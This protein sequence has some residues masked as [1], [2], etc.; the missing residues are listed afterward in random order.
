MKLLE[1]IRCAVDSASV[2]H[3]RNISKPN[4]DRLIVDNERGIYIVL[5]GITRPHSEYRRHPNESMAGE[6]GDI[7]L[8]ECY[9]YIKEHLDSG[10][11]EKILRAATKSANEKLDE[12]RTKKSNVKWDFFP[13]TIGIIALLSGSTLHYLCVGDSMGVLVRGNSKI[14]FGKEFALEAVDMLSL[15][16]KERYDHYCNHPENPLSYSVFNGDD[17]V[18]ETAEY[19][20]LDIHE[21]DT[22][23]IATD[24]ICNY[25]KFEKC[26][27]IVKQSADEIIASSSTYDA[28]PYARYADDKTLIK[29]SF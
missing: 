12:Y 13:A 4:E 23:F 20:F 5:D 6:V 8:S 27:D 3:N 2:I 21:G 11:P 26:A 19:S 25:L 24:G 7:F 14:L 29:L 15:S 18:A 1:K 22:V 10:N 17:F 9:A 16:K 28:P